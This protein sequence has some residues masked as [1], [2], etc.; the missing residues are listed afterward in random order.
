MPNL[1]QTKTRML[2]M[3]AL[4]VGGTLVGGALG[5]AAG[6]MLAASALGNIATTVAGEASGQVH[7][8]RLEGVARRG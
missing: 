3:G 1:G 4:M 7:F 5:G 6:G 2:S 8:L